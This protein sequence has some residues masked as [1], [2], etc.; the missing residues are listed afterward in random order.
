ME[1]RL[2]PL[3]VAARL[4]AWIDVDHADER[5]VDVDLLAARLGVTVAEFA[6]RFQPPG[7]LGFLEPGEDL[8][9]LRQGLSLPIR[10]FTLAHE[11]GHAVLHRT[12]GAVAEVLHAVL[13]EMPSALEED[14]ATCVARDLDTPLD[15]LAMDDEQLAP[16]QAYSARSRRE[17]Q[18]NAFAAALLLPSA[19]LLHA[20]L[21]APRDTTRSAQSLARRFGVSEDVVLRRLAA[22]LVE[23]EADG[24]AASHNEPAAPHPLDR[25][26]RAAAAAEAPALVVAGPGTGK[27][28][29]LVG[30]VAYLV[31]E[32]GVACEAILALTFS[33]KAAREMRERVEELLATTSIGNFDSSTPSTVMPTIA[34]IHAYCGELLRQYAPLVGLRPDFRLVTQAEGYFLLRTACARLPLVHYQPIAAPTQYFPELLGAISRAKDELAAPEDYARAAESMTARASAG[35]ERDAAARAS[36]VAGIYAAYQRTLEARGDADF[37]DLVRLTVRLLR[38]HPEVR[39]QVRA[40]YAAIL[41]DEFQ[42]INRAM[43]VLLRELAGAEGSLWAVGDADQAIYRF[44]GAS[45]ANLA[46]FTDDYPRA[47]VCRLEH[48]Y[49]SAPPILAAAA[50]VAGSLLG[51][52]D[53]RPL[54]ATRSVEADPVLTLATAPNE[55]AEIA[56]LVAAIEAYRAAGR[57]AEEIAVLCRTRRLAQRAAAA[58]RAANIPVC[59]PAPLLEQEK[60]KDLLA[61][62][63][64]LADPGGAGW[65][66][67]GHS[68]AHAYTRADAMALLSAAR[69]RAVSPLRLAATEDEYP[70]GNLG[71]WIG[72][73][74]ASSCRAGQATNGA[75]RGHRAGTLSL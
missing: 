28:S 15:L 19:A 11:L 30:R 18:A 63:A 64:L 29:T 73:S 70:A 8:I 42:D 13:G 65:L 3:H 7:T 21:G 71:V 20:S 27:T 75:E 41:V 46:R 36:E 67:A 57:G 32:R 16:G 50:A 34:T 14:V 55:D 6:P 43:G 69:E 39:E 56:G 4:R 66:R 72:G 62:F 51:H 53:A 44:R 9:F 60:I 38:E 1:S 40:R 24:R 25:A 59:M 74:G 17:M 31:R 2:R 35:D 49:R 33:N 22:L 5:M 47:H 12:G 52:A 58:L 61:V 68:P 54:V 37:G 23:R 48:N 10:R 26:Q 45:P